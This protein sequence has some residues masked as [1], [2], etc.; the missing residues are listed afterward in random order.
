VGTGRSRRSGRRR[1]R[2]SSVAPARRAERLRSERH[3]RQSCWRAP[4]RRTSSE[5]TGSS[6]S[7]RA[8][9]GRHRRVRPTGPP[10]RRRRS[11]RARIRR[12][13]GR[14]APARVRGSTSTT[15]RRGQLA[16]QGSGGRQ[17]AGALLVG[18]RRHVERALVAKSSTVPTSPSHPATVACRPVG[19]QRG[20]GRGA[21]PTVRRP[22][23]RWRWCPDAAAA[24]P[25]GT[26][27]RA[28]RRRQHQG[29]RVGG[30]SAPEVMT[31]TLSA[32][33]VADPP[34]HDGPVSVLPR[35]RVTRV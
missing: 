4:R 11:G 13:T 6:A 32:R 3:R 8:T 27:Q 25:E 12:R 19:P 9:T 34:V 7:R 29:P 22:V 35:R 14:P 20:R 1:R 33:R 24:A 18:D 16:G 2:S 30:V 10:V 5:V 26:D 23:P 15:Q 21:R 17:E 31:S 28:S